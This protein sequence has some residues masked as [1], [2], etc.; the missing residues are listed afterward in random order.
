MLPTTKEKSDIEEALDHSLS[1]AASLAGAISLLERG[2]KKAAPSNKMF[3]QMLK[4]Y[5]KSLSTFREYIKSRQ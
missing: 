1:L 2:G 4:D 5:K 3:Y